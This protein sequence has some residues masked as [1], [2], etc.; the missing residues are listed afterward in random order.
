MRVA[1]LSRDGLRLANLNRRK[2]IRARC[3][4]CS[5]WSFD[6]VKDCGFRDCPLYPFRSGQGRQNA[7]E[8]MKAIKRYCLW[9]MAGQKPEITKCVS[10]RCPLFAFRKGERLDRSIAIISPFLPE[11]EHIHATFQTISDE[12]IPNYGLG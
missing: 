11:K 1:I 8:R 3:L 5:G 7:K 2:A 4:D 6:E 10:V 12:P 9:C